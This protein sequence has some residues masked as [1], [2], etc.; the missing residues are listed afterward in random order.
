[1][2]LSEVGW[3]DGSGGGHGGGREGGDGGSF[4]VKCALD[5][6]YV[7]FCDNTGFGVRHLVEGCLQL[8]TVVKGARR[9]N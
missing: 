9:L 2:V 7:L 1:M 8:R 6:R 3:C 4:C 5:A